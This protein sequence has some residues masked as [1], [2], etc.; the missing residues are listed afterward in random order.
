LPA[1]VVPVMHSQSLTSSEA[2]PLSVLTGHSVHPPGP[3]EA[4]YLPAVQAE[5]PE[6]V[7]PASHW[8]AVAALPV[9][10]WFAGHVRHEDC[11]ELGW[12]SLL[13]Y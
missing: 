13:E 8:Q 2:D 10:L 11:P 5:Q 12:Y 7:Y 3:V 9:G 1:A 4:L 6:P